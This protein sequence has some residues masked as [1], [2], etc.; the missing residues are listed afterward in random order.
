MKKILNRRYV[1]MSAL[2]LTLGSALIA[3]EMAVANPNAPYDFN[4][5]VYGAN[6]QAYPITVFSS[7]NNLYVQ[8]PAK[9]KVF[10]VRTSTE[11]SLE[12]TKFDVEH[13]YIVVPYYG[14]TTVFYTSAGTVRI[15]NEGRGSSSVPSAAMN[16][17]ENVTVANPVAPANKSTNLASAAIKAN[18]TKMDEPTA[19]SSLATK[20]VTIPLSASKPTLL[21]TEAAKAGELE[22][23]S[24]PAEFSNFSCTSP[25][26]N[27]GSP[28]QEI[29]HTIMR[30]HY[31]WTLSKALDK[32]V[33]E[34]FKVELSSGI[35]PAMGVG[36]VA[37]APW[38]ITLREINRNNYLCGV[39]DWNKRTIYEMERNS[40][41]MAHNQG[42]EHINPPKFNSTVEE[43]KKN[44]YFVFSA[45]K[46]ESLSHALRVFLSKNGKWNYRFDSSVNT[47]FLMPVQITGSSLLSVLNK[48]GKDTGFDIK[49]YPDNNAVV[50]TFP[51]SEPNGL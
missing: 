47:K 26:V 45:K 23:S 36:K 28:K 37:P 40:K 24:L 51:N 21:A 48:V 9:V 1:V 7:E 13:P 33:P 4:Y 18:H 8:F 11:G 14:N 27:I 29:I 38:N 10:R 25:I 31:S 17:E 44:S 5:R 30:P 12:T 43:V 32:V 16:K 41:V 34:T 15:A 35:N 46:G 2:A 3:P 42:L 22:K 39:I 20:T 49:I 50:V 19:I 6:T